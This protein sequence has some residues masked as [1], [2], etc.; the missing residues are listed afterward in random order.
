M[1]KFLTLFAF[2]LFYHNLYSQY[3]SPGIRLGY[4]FN[5]HTT[6]ELKVSLGVVA[7]G[8]AFNVTIGKKYALSNTESYLPH[9][10]LDLQFGDFTETIGK[11]KAQL[12][13]G[14]GIGVVFYK[15]EGVTHFHPGI[16]TFA[17]FAFFA[18]A[19]FYLNE[20]NIES[21]LGLQFVLPLPLGGV[22]FGSPG[23]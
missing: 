5:S 16:T 9:N 20:S 6:F 14:G 11:R 3:V 17:G 21:D 1:Y 19:D 23:G 12:F 10:Y 7:D 13:Y 15:K 2:I 8:K 18:T 4:D 22:D